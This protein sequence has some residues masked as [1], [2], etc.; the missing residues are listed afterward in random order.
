MTVYKAKGLE[1]EHVF[2]ICCQDDVWGST[3][4]SSANRLTLPANLKPI[5]KSGTTDDERLRILFVAITRAKAGLYLTSFRNTFS[6]KLTKSLKYLNEQ[7][8]DDGSRRSLVLPEHAQLIVTNDSERPAVEALAT[9]WQHRHLGSLPD[10]ELQQ[11]LEDR[12]TRYQLSPTHLNQFTDVVYGGPQKFFMNTILRFPQA[13]TINGQYGSAIHEVLEWIQHKVN[14][15]GQL[16]SAKSVIDYFAVVMK[17]ANLTPAQIELETERGTHALSAYMKFRGPAFKPGNIAEHNFKNEGVFVSEA[18]LGGKIDLIE[19]DQATKTICVV[20]Y[21]TGSWYAKWK[22]DAKLHKYREQL[23]AYKLLIE[24]SHRFKGYTVTS[25]RIEFIE[26]DGQGNIYSLDL[27][28]DSK[29][30]ERVK[31]L[32]QAMWKHVKALDL[33]DISKYSKDLKGI[34]A[35]ENDLLDIS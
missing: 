15:K 23:Y 25:G 31:A 9:N 4:R 27:E 16:P 35:F 17:K 33:P 14:D 24:G 32:I 22:S 28:F 5:R 1:F 12:I 8:Q 18:H 26:P 19:I 7:E 3:S 10:L 2:V 20:D 13:P 34:Q 29:E 21:K 6:G 11:L 30:L